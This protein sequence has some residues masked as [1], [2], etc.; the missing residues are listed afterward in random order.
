[1]KLNKELITEKLDYVYTESQLERMH[2]DMLDDVFGEVSIA[3]YTYQTSDALLSTDPTAHQQSFLDY[4]DSVCKDEGLVEIDGYYYS[5]TDIE[6]L[7]NE[8]D[9]EE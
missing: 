4:V 1:M 2:Q 8:S 9:E 5:E 6:D 7:E 3:G